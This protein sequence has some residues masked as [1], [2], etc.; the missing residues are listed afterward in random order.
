[1]TSPDRLDSEIRQ[2][3]R[4]AARNG[5]IVRVRQCAEGLSSA[6]PDLSK[7]EM[8]ERIIREAVAAKAALELDR[9]EN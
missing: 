6:Y 3:M 9:L 1:M 4:D 8:S 2:K 5:Q 7:K